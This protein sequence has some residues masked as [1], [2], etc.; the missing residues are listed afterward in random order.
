MNTPQRPLPLRAATEAAGA[1]LTRLPRTAWRH[2]RAKN[3][4]AVFDDVTPTVPLIAATF[5]SHD[6]A[7][8]WADEVARLNPANP[9]IVLDSAG[10]TQ[11][12]IGPDTRKA[13]RA[14]TAAESIWLRCGQPVKHQQPTQLDLP[15]DTP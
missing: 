15:L 12:T 14:A 7:T 1:T 3:T 2:A 8:Q 9:V 10:T 5:K 6:D 11:L 4:V 13:N